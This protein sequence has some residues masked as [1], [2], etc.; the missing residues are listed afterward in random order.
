[1]KKWKLS[2]P[3]RFEVRAGGR[4]LLVMRYWYRDTRTVT[5]TIIVVWKGTYMYPLTSHAASVPCSALAFR[6]QACNC[7][8]KVT[9]MQVRANRTWVRWLLLVTLF[10]LQCCSPRDDGESMSM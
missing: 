4:L 3:L 7:Y 10:V 9:C 1:M 5:V 8:N 6:A 2:S